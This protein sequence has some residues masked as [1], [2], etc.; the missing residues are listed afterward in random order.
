MWLLE[1]DL[2]GGNPDQG[3][4]VDQAFVTIA[5]NGRVLAETADR[6]GFDD[7]PWYLQAG[8]M[9]LPF[10][11]HF[12]YHTFDVISEP[13][14]LEL[15]ETLETALQ[16]GWIPSGPVHLF[17]GVYS[18]RG[19][20]G[21]DELSVEEAKDDEANGF[22]VGATGDFGF[23]SAAVSWISNLNDSIALADELSVAEDAVGGLNLY[24]SADLGPARLQL[25]YV[26]ALDDY[27]VGD[28]AG[29]Q[30]WAL[31]AELTFE[32]LNVGGREMAVTA[33]YWKTD[34]WVERAENTYGIVIDTAL[35]DGITLSAQYL[36]RDYDEEFS[37]LD[38]DDLIAVQLTTEFGWVF[39]Q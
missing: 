30:P 8:K 29:Q 39:G 31:A 35:A 26:S 22:F 7:S 20:D 25:S 36:H 6:D 24:G 3:F 10:A 33:V 19:P 21:N 15:G 27:T 38:S 34:E 18:G 9:Y 17:A 5:G 4:A 2:A 11:T 1:E 28:Y 37:E 12:E 23:G 14:T 32:G 13:Y 16:I